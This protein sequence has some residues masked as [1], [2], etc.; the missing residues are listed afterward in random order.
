MKKLAKG[1]FILKFVLPALLLLLL[2]SNIVFFFK[3]GVS[4]YFTQELDDM[5]G[6]YGVS[7]ITIEEP[8]DAA[9]NE[10]FTYRDGEEYSIRLDKDS[11]G[12][13]CFVVENLTSGGGESWIE[14]DKFLSFPENVD[15]LI[16]SK[17]IH[18]QG[19]IALLDATDID[20]VFERI[21]EKKK[22]WYNVYKKTYREI[23]KDFEYRYHTEVLTDDAGNTLYD[24]NGNVLTH[25]VRDPEPTWGPD[26]RWVPDL[27]TEAGL[28]E[29]FYL[30]TRNNFLAKTEVEA[31]QSD[32]G[33][34]RFEVNWQAVLALMEMTSSDEEPYWGKATD[35]LGNPKDSKADFTTTRRE[36]NKDDYFLS[37]AMID[38]I[39][40]L[41]DYE[42]TY[43]WDAFKENPDGTP[44]EQTFR[45]P[46]LDK[47]AYRLEYEDYD[48]E[49]GD[50]LPEY[51]ELDAPAEAYVKKTPAVAP[52]VIKNGY[53]TLTYIYV[54]TEDDYSD[55]IC[56]GRRVTWDA[57]GFYNRVME[58]CPSFKWS[59]YKTSIN[60]FPGSSSAVALAEELEGVFK[61]QCALAEGTLRYEDGSM[62]DIKNLK[63]GKKLVG[64]YG[65]IVMQEMEDCTSVDVCLGK[66]CG[67]AIEDTTII[68]IGEATPYDGEIY[69]FV[70]VIK[71]G[72]YCK[73]DG[74]V[75]IYAGAN[76]NLLESDNLSH[77]QIVALME[78]FE[79]KYGN[80]NG[81][82]WIDAVNGL[83]NWQ[84]ST[85]ASITGMLAIWMSE[86]AV[87]GNNGKNHW[88]FGNYVAGSHPSFQNKVGG[89]SWWDVKAEYPNFSDAIY[90]QMF[91]IYNRYW[92]KGQSTYYAMSWWTGNGTVYSAQSAEEAAALTSS[93]VHCYCPYWDDCGIIPHEE[94]VASSSHWANNNA[95]NRDKLLSVVG[96]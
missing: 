79:Q 42:F 93:L 37:D 21:Y 33:L 76:K 77:E 86:G 4:E 13:L 75:S 41:F 5:R 34:Y 38:E 11:E 47:I 56:V 26:E 57:I 87:S 65:P 85:N 8:G 74:W 10:R 91:D 63:P 32:G 2:L 45:Y 44:K 66:D 53:E 52:D 83:E 67:E 84:T 58:F 46:D 92:K 14:Y 50:D 15:M 81:A 70:Y 12:K 43:K 69:D 3:Y 54:D 94:K 31:E 17:A 23:S 18:I 90:N 71:S 40:S 25:E 7:G 80:P 27:D 72:R 48:T 78:F 28:R 49:I 89:Y 73:S 61:L 82:K 55:K 60:Y 6:R 22:S 24:S 64:Y 96:R 51:P 36:L 16:I 68:D 9:E 30:T 35:S 20:T 88:N 1:L 95:V 39:M 59:S 62:V 19:D 29:H